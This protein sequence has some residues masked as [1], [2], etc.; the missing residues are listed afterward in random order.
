M[1]QILPQNILPHKTPDIINA[2]KTIMPT[3]DSAISSSAIHVCATEE[4]TLG[5]T[6]VH[7]AFFATWV[8]QAALYLA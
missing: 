6:G 4:I 1:G 2:A 8:R 3:T 5:R 7:F